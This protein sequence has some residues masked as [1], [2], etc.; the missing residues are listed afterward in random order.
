MNV[1][2]LSDPAG[3][4]RGS[5]VLAIDTTT[6]WCSVAIVNEASAVYSDGQRLGHGHSTRAL[7]MCDALLASQRLTLADV[8]AFAF[9]AGPGSFTG[10]RIGCGLMQGMAYAAGKPCVGIDSL[11]ARTVSARQSTERSTEPSVRVLQAVL[12]DARMGQWYAGCYDAE[13][14]PIVAPFVAAPA[15]AAH[16]LRQANAEADPVQYWHDPGLDPADLAGLTGPG[17]GGWSAPL[18]P[19][20]PAL[21]ARGVAL[22]ARRALPVGHDAAS[23]GAALP[24][25]VRDKVA[26]DVN[27]QRSL[28]ASRGGA[29]R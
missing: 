22:L 7:A 21:I 11:A 24:L 5:I 17:P 14:E 10:V 13:G 29:S 28:R 4:A 25:Y 15:A 18:S 16:W 20:D 9:G 2:Q 8:D 27:E 26:L 1:R 3:R 19:L 12:V 6:A 23:I